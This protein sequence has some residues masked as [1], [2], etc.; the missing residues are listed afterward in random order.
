MDMWLWW[1]IVII[2][3]AVIEAVTINL[4]SIWFIASGFVSLILSFFI[5][6]FYLQFAI[7]VSLGLILMLL[8][9]PFLVKRLVRKTE[10]TNLDRVIGMKGVVTEEITRF[11]I[12][13]AKVDGKK[14]SAISDEKISIGDLVVVTD[15]DGVKLKVRKDVL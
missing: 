11:K 12:G 15:I 3:L 8:T 4:V 1:L 5:D 13:E 7:F 6:S 9:R 14:W 10:K 2:L